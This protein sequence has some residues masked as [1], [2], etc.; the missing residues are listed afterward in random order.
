MEFVL[1]VSA[2][3]QHLMAQPLSPSPSGCGPSIDSVASCTRSSTGVGSEDVINFRAILL[4]IFS[5]NDDGA[6]NCRVTPLF[7]LLPRTRRRCSSIVVLMHIDGRTRR[8]QSCALVPLGPAVINL[9]IVWRSLCENL[10]AD[11]TP[12]VRLDCRG[13]EGSWESSC[14][15]GGAWGW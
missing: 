7:R 1:P 3:R 4:E 6:T 15:T 13:V 14:L 10:T 2:S 5:Q 11:L 12:R 8:R 9:S